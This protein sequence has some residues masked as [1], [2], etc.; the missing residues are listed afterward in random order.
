MGNRPDGVRSALGQSSSMT[1]ASCRS[2]GR[3]AMHAF[4]F[5]LGSRALDLA[6]RSGRGVGPH[7]V[8][9]GPIASTPETAAAWRRWRNAGDTADVNGRRDL[10]L[11]RPIVRTHP[12]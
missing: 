2:V 10:A 4:G 6:R 1:G 8:V 9:L 11:G 5:L 3:T 12:G 7:E